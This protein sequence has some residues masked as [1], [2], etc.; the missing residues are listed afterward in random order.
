MSPRLRGLLTPTLNACSSSPTRAA[1]SASSVAMLAT[2]EPLLAFMAAR[3]SASVS[4]TTTESS[5]PNGS[6]WCS[7]QDGGGCS[8]QAGAAYAETSW[9]S[10]KAPSPTDPR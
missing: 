5:G 10:T 3:N 7:D 2:S 4:T 1:K 8:T 6:A 9:P